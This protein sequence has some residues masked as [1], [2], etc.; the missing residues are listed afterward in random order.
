MTDDLTAIARLIDALR[1]WH[2]QLV[3]VGGWAHR[4]HRFHAWATVP[5][6]VPLRTRDADVAFSLDARLAGDIRAALEAAGFKE[7]LSGDHRPPV[8]EYRLG[9]E[10]GGFFA[11]FLTPLRGSGTKTRSG[12]DDATAERAGVTAQKLRHLELLLTNP[13]PVRL[14]VGTRLPLERPA[15]VLLANPVSFI[16]Q[17]ILIRKLRATNKQPQDVL[18]IHD[19]LELFAD[20]RDE[21]RALWRETIRPTLHSR[22]ARD[23]ERR[24][25][26]Q[27]GRVDDVIRQAARIPVGRSLTPERIQAACALGLE[28]ILGNPG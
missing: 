13:W 6:Y 3:I 26:E 12:R 17:K 27:F 11:E 22:T 16:A 28:E 7:E 25:K 21:L 19:T 20:R 8:A 23:V 2:E 1:P 24:G 5:S 14:D 4:L 9:E 15:D 10:H 18:Y